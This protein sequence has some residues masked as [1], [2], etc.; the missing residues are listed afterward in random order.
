MLK[1]RRW[2]YECSLKNFSFATCLKTFIIKWGKKQLLL[3]DSNTLIEK[4]TLG[5]KRHFTEYGQTREDVQRCSL[6]QP[7]S[8]ETIAFF[9]Y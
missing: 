3:V 9:T 2:V 5:M 8:G 4:G 6:S 1:S 7:Q